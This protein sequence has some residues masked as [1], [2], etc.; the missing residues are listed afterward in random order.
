M[1]VPQ[2][3]LWSRA[4]RAFSW[5]R[6]LRGR[7]GARIMLSFALGALG[8]SLAVTTITYFATRSSIIGQ[9]GLV[10]RKH[11]GEQRHHR[12]HRS[13]CHPRSAQ[14][15]DNI[16]QETANSS[17]LLH[18]PGA[19]STSWTSTGRFSIIYSVLPPSLLRLANSGTPAEQIFQ[20]PRAGSRFVVVGLPVVINRGTAVYVEAFPLAQAAKELRF[21][22]AA[23]I[24]A[25]AVTTLAGAILGRWA[26][27]RALRPLREVSQAALAIAEGLLDT[28]I[29]TVGASDLAVLASSFNRMV[30]R[31]QQR[32]ERRG[33]VHLGM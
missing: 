5:R 29:E 2:L 8:L 32:I 9:Y 28:R 22:L 18:L 21:L 7:L 30:D 27:R 20:P 17:S 3:S 25:A 13:P 23:L 14:I 26:A 33:E 10:S 24:F 12:A 16:D 4:S 19:K 31:L 6:H 11:R 1:E 15:V